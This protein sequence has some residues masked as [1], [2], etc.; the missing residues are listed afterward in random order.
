[1]EAFA[2]NEGASNLNTRLDS[3]WDAATAA[4]G[5]PSDVAL[6]R[7][8]LSAGNDFGRAVSGMTARLRQGMTAVKEEL[9]GV[10][11][12][13][14]RKLSEVAELDAV[15]MEAGG[16]LSSGD[17]ADRRDQLV[18]EVSEMMGLDYKI[19]ED[20]TAELYL[21]GHVVSA[22]GRA[23]SL[24]F[25]Q[26]PTTGNVSLF[27]SSGDGR[28]D[29]TDTLG[30]AIGGYVDALEQGNEWVSDLDTVA[31]NF[32]DTINAQH[33][34]G[35]DSTGAAGGDLFTYD[36]T[37]PAGSLSVAFDD[38][39][40]LALASQ[41]TA[42][43]GDGGNLDALRAVEDQITV[44]TRTTRQALSDWGSSMGSTVATA[45]LRSEQQG[46]IQQD[47]EELHASMVGVS[48]DEEA[49]RMIEAQTAYQAGAKVIQA[50]DRMFSVLL[51]L[52]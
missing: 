23:R 13:V 47:L 1:L 48:L 52:V 38:P 30:G 42:H 39:S 14:S 15:I 26:D 29:V 40:G 27:L 34:L 19:A 12:E 35:F 6:R 31:T 7:Q 25:E 33:A 3:F 50:T 20:Q 4:T 22:N 49:A 51:E 8:L 5:D 16:R 44:G 41:S 32:A 43:A 45:G 28:V 37:D 11:V 24:E 10:S 46:Y 9:S 36:V 18:Y 17:A 21:G 2:S